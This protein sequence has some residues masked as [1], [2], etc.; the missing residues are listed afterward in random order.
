MKNIFLVLIC[1]YGL[2]SLQSCYYDNPPQLI[3]FECSDVSYSTH[4]I[5]IFESSCSTQGCHDGSHEPDLRSN[6]ARNSLRSGGYLNTA[7]PEESKL[8]KSVDFIESDMPPGGKL[9][10]LE[11]ELI[12]CWISEGAL[13]N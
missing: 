11:L 12:M 5:P 4:I 2:F 6:L 10:S 13:D 3:P 9:P 8:W 1:L 7:I